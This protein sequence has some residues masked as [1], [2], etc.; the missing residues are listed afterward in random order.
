[1]DKST[2]EDRGEPVTLME[3][4]IVQSEGRRREELADLALQLTSRS[5][6]LRSSLPSGIVTALSHLV[7]S[8]NCYYSN[9]IE[10]HDTHPIDIER[11]LNEDFSHDPKQRDLQLEARAHIDVQRWIDN[12]GLSD[13]ANS[14]ASIVEMHR[15]F[16]HA[17]PED[18]LWVEYPDSG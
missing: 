14:T 2:A 9:L 11:A 4:L 8:M 16:C 18:L 10:G 6:T 5:T 13:K 3:P 7:R 12:G 15:R 17:L 1:M